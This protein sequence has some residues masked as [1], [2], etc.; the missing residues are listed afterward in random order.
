MNPEIIQEL[1]DVPSEEFSRYLS[2]DT[3]NR[4]IFSS[5]FGSGKTTFLEY[6]FEENH[7]NRFLE[8][9]IYI[10]IKIYP[11]NYSISGNEDVLRYIK[12]DILKATIPYQI[13]PKIDKKAGKN[14]FS[15]K[16][17]S[18][19]NSVLNIWGKLDPNVE[20]FRETIKNANYL[21]DEFKNIIK[22]EISENDNPTNE[23]I[24]SFIESIENSPGSIYEN[25]IL[26]I[27][28]NKHIQ[29]I[30][31]R[32]SGEKKVQTILIIDDLDRLD[33]E[34]IFRILNIFAT[35][36]DHNT[37]K[38]WLGID[39]ILFVCDIDNIQNIFFHKYG[40]E[41]DFKGYIDKF[42]SKG[43]FYYTS[44]IILSNL[45]DKFKSNITIS[46]PRKGSIPSLQ[47]Y[48]LENN[49]ILDLILKDFIIY[50][51]IN[52]RNLERAGNIFEFKSDYSEKQRKETPLD[53]SKLFFTIS[54][55]S[56]SFFGGNISV[57]ENSIIR[58]EKRLRA[59]RE[60]L[61]IDSCLYL[62][63]VDK[64]KGKKKENVNYGVIELKHNFSF[65]ILNEDDDQIKHRSS[66]IGPNVQS[67]FHQSN[68]YILL[69]E[70]VRSLKNNH[71]LH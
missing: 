32:K 1:I 29:N 48:Y 31:S 23:E 8:N 60:A 68:D 38:N 4:L 54:F 16:L 21:I 13:P 19:L 37:G 27:A 69:I 44:A 66:A 22:T 56:E 59:R 51:E 49:K 18:K 42:Y 26:N 34:H 41:T 14:T 50:G 17:I 24:D 62:L 40:N 3:N 35:Y 43:I 30:V 64:H 9:E 12:Y 70:T 53:N 45:V 58:I 46:R 28:I 20:K 71:I 61:L 10:P 67:L 25:N 65:D 7:Q 39:K 33:P 57:F 2:D 36:F 52:I 47:S 15:L 5:K 6:F 63:T 11:V 55:I